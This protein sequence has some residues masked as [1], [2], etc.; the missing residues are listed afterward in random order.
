[1]DT[2][3]KVKA[4]YDALSELDKKL[5][6]LGVKN[7]Q[8][9][10]KSKHT[11]EVI[12][13]LYSP[14]IRPYKDKETGEVSDK[15]PP[16]IKLKVPRRNKQ[17]SCQVFNDER[18][19]VELDSVVGKGALVQALIKCTGIW[20][21]GGKYGSSWTIEQMKVTPSKRLH[22]YSFLSDS[23]DEGSDSEDSGSGD[24]SE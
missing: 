24:D 19:A 9:W 12:K 1:M 4:L 20:F 6:S 5:V 17:F 13:A 18:E 3:D 2:D 15:Y 10:F 11:K 21:A 23:D 7:S 8:K 16:T 22:G 14:I